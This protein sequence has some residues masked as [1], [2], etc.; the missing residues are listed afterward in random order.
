M[1]RRRVH[2]S[3]HRGR[4]RIV[5]GLGGLL[6]LAAAGV[7]VPAFVWS[8]VSLAADPSALARIAVEP[9]E[10][11]SRRLSSSTATAELFRSPSR[12]TA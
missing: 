12:A 1:Q 3:G 8:G 10:G 9:F 6:A 7:I 2:R 11:T 5:L 4:L